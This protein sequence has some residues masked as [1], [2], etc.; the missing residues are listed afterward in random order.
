MGSVN[1]FKKIGLTFFLKIK[2]FHELMAVRPPPGA[3]GSYADGQMGCAYGAFANGGR[4]HK[5]SYADD[6]N[7]LI[8]NST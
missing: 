2:Q 5:I 8:S 1:Q 3:H 7:G 4:R 6:Q